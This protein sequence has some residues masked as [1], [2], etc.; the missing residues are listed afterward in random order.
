MWDHFTDT[1]KD[2][3]STKKLNFLKIGIE[4]H[5][6]YDQIWKEK[7]VIY[8]KPKKQMK[9]KTLQPKKISFITQESRI[10]SKIFNKASSTNFIIKKMFHFKKN[11]YDKKPVKKNLDQTEVKKEKGNKNKKPGLFPYIQ[12]SQKYKNALYNYN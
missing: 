4:N 8:E 6:Y 10:H 9:A 11:V 1:N 7:D 3:F 12:N 5:S 2:D